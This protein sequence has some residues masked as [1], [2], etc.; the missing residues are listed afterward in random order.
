VAEWSIGSDG[1]PVFTPNPVVLPL[2]TGQKGL[3]TD[4]NGSNVVGLMGAPL[5]PDSRI[6]LRCTSEFH[7]WAQGL[8]DH[9]SLNVTQLVVQGLIRI[10]EGSGYHHKIPTRYVPKNPSRRRSH[11]RPSYS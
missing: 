10:A 2:E 8:A 7:G 5:S 4:Q 9:V 3:E 1:Q 11:P 6:V